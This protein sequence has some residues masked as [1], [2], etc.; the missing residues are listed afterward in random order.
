MSIII[1][2][3][4]LYPGQ[5]WKY[6]FIDDI[7]IYII[8]EVVSK[9]EIYVYG[10]D[11]PFKEKDFHW[12]HPIKSVKAENADVQAKVFESFERYGLEFTYK[13]SA[14][15]ALLVLSCVLII[16]LGLYYLLR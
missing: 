11:F 8:E 1:K 14:F 12:L 6:Q 10:F 2:N 7:R 13:Q 4:T 3:I 16:A 5:I 9:E 15:N